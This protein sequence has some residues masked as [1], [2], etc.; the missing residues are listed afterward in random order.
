MH[1]RSFG[2]VRHRVMH[3]DYN[4]GY[5]GA[6][7][8]SRDRSRM[9]SGGNGA[10][11]EVRIW[12]T[13]D[14]S[15]I[16]S[17]NYGDAIREAHLLRFSP[18]ATLVAGADCNGIVVWEVASGRKLAVIRPPHMQCVYGG[19]VGNP[20]EDVVFSEDGSTLAASYIVIGPPADPV[21]KDQGGAFLALHRSRDGK[22][23]RRWRSDGSPSQNL[24][25][26]T[27]D[28]S[29]LAG[30]NWRFD[31]K[32][33]K[34]LE[35]EHGVEGGRPAATRWLVHGS[36]EVVEVGPGDRVQ[37]FALRGGPLEQI[38]PYFLPRSTGAG[39]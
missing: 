21:P 23:L 24:E 7:A 15:L 31:L 26:F 35:I 4:E 20:V 8:F 2:V 18:D 32:A 27:P 39:R 10:D 36:E 3:D 37:A 22:L 29:M 28:Q 17:I 11:K 33:G 16:Q 38:G 9:A 34:K 13:A 12:R 6:I 5:H 14:R 30:L 19:G 25:A 1:D